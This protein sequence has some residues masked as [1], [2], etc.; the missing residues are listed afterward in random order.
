MSGRYL[1]DSNVAIAV[2][3]RKLDIAPYRDQGA[4][5]YL[6]AIVVGELCL[7]AENSDRR[8]QNFAAVRRFLEICPAFPCTEATGPHY[9]R[10]HH[11]LR[12]CGKP[13]TRSLAAGFR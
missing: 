11:R 8:E 7:G 10:V 6:N 5:I 13:T 4:T 1:L 3:N 2:L 12:L 9:A